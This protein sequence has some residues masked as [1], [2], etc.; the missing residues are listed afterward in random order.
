MRN[1]GFYF[2]QAMSSQMQDLRIDCPD[3]KTTAGSHRVIEKKEAAMQT[4]A[5]LVE[6]ADGLF[7]VG[8]RGNSWKG[9]VYKLEGGKKVHAGSNGFVF[10]DAPGAMRLTYDPLIGERISIYSIIEVV[11]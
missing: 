11:R 1:G 4:E 6:T 7:F 9:D 5:V 2:I 10:S 3:G 8:K